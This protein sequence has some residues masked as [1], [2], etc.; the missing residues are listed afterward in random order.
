MWTAA[1]S[2]CLSAWPCRPPTPESLNAVVCAL[3]ISRF[4]RSIHAFVIRALSYSQRLDAVKQAPMCH[5]PSMSTS[6]ACF[7]RMCRLTNAHYDRHR[8]VF[9]GLRGRQLGVNF[10]P[11]ITARAYSY[12]AFIWYIIVGACVCNTIRK[13]E[14]AV[15]SFFQTLASAIGPALE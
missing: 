11:L 3:G 15:N 1:P 12:T 10:L 4:P 8:A 13:D 14:K 5:R 2:A 6:T 9:Y 7:G